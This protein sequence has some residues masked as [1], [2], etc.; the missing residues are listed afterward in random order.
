MLEVVSKFNIERSRQREENGNS[1]IEW[2]EASE[3]VPTEAVKAAEDSRTPRRCRDALRAI[4][5]VR[6]GSAA[7]L[8]RFDMRS[9]A[10]GFR[11]KIETLRV[12]TSAA[13]NIETS[14]TIK[15]E[16][17][18]GVANTQSRLLSIRRVLPM[19]TAKARCAPR[20][21]LVRGVSVC[22]SKNST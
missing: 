16:K 13:T 3:R 12:V 1:K 6:S 8:Y 20:E 18:R 17:R 11:R 21:T 19:K 22:G 7:V 9:L 4:H 2:H 14:S 5:S 10:G 15:E